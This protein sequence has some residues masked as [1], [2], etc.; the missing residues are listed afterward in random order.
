MGRAAAGGK[1]LTANAKKGENQPGG[2]FNPGDRHPAGNVHRAGFNLAMGKQGD[3]ALVAGL[4]RVV[5]EELVERFAGGES[6]LEKHQ[7]D[8]RGRDGR[9]AHHRKMSFNVT[10]LARN[11]AEPQVFRKP[12][13]AAP[14]GRLAF[15]KLF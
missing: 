9:P 10:Q 1:K 5:M 11:N 8:Q 12:K 14:T 7:A 6:E 15:A 13:K 2:G 3:R 4:V